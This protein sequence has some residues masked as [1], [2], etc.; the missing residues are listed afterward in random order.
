MKTQPSKPFNFFETHE[1][2]AGLQIVVIDADDEIW[3][4][5]IFQ[6]WASNQ[7]NLPSGETQYSTLACWEF[8]NPS[9]MEI[10]ET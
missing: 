2:Q 5:H 6:S 10:P 4:A 3:R 9:P 8:I 7:T 1:S